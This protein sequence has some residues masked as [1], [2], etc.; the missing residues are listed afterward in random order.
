MKTPPAGNGPDDLSLSRECSRRYLDEVVKTEELA[1]RPSRQPDHAAESRALVALACEMADS[2]RTILQKLVDTAL[3]LCRAGSA[4]ISILETE[5]GKEIFRWHALA[6]A[7]V[8]FL[9]GTTPRDF[10]P[11]GI[12]LDRNAPQL[13]TD[14]E[15]YYPYIADLS[16]HVAELLLIPFYR[17]TRPVGTVWVVA[18][19]DARRFD[20]EDA[21][22]MTSLSRFASAA[23]ESLTNLDAIEAGA[24]V[25]TLGTPNWSGWG[26]PCVT[27]IG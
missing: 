25:L 18:H 1:R 27:R 6:G 2:P 23:V 24:R 13:M 10:S 12:V 26:P 9:R 4:G 14:P 21:R 16:P 20:A 7:F 11:C 19:D 8:P 5:A 17:G 22:L 3:E 15:R